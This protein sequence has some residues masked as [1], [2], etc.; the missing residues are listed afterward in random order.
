MDTQS[1]SNPPE[2]QS[3]KKRSGGT[4]G[5][6]RIPWNSVTELE[7]RGDSSEGGRAT[8]GASEAGGAYVPLP[9]MKGWK[10]GAQTG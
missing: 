8:A 3:D 5:G 1:F 6:S 2:G 4:L 9:A 10:G 7:R